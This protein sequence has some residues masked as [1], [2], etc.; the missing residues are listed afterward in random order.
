MKPL[1]GLVLNS[2]AATFEPV[3]D[4]QRQARTSVSLAC[5]EWPN[6]SY[7]NL[8]ISYGRTRTASV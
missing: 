1:P 7:S 2:G 8:N 6:A 4:S 5:L 3:S